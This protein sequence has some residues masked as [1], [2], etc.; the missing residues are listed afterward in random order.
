[1][2]QL[3]NDIN[4]VVNSSYFSSIYFIVEYNN[5]PFTTNPSRGVAPL[6]QRN[7]NRADG[8]DAR[9]STGKGNATCRGTQN[10]LCDDENTTHS[11]NLARSTIPNF[12]N[13]LTP[14]LIRSREDVIGPRS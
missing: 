5:L 3:S 9:N 7:N 12:N 10:N 6:S 14:P 8:D 13:P 2:N 11:G 1:M 4:I